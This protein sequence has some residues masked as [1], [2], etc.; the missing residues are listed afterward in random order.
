MI[1]DP[2]YADINA[3]AFPSCSREE[4]AR[5]CKRILKKFGK[6]SLGSALQTKDA[7]W[8]R[9]VRRCWISPR[10]TTGHHK[11]WGR[12]IHDLAH[13]I[14]RARHPTFRPHDPGHDTL[15]REILIFC[16]ESG[17]LDGRLLPFQ[18]PKPTTEQKRA[19]RLASVDARL[20]R[21]HAKHKRA[22]T[23]IQKLVRERRRLEKLVMVA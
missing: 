2:R 15:E 8:P 3:V 1:A 13:V 21:W 14:F 11:G 18:K 19:K 9:A 20:T 17:F 12:L 23:A 5:A 10:P 22:A 6:K 16:Q 7:T 4:S